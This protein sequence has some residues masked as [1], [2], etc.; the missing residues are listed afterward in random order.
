M[1]VKKDFEIVV[2]FPV[3]TGS[4]FAVGDI[5][6]LGEIFLPGW[7]DNRSIT[8]IDAQIIDPN[9]ATMQPVVVFH[10]QEPNIIGTSGDPY[11]YDNAGS[12]QSNIGFIPFITANQVSLS[13]IMFHNARNVGL[14]LPVKSQRLYVSA[15]VATGT[16]TL[17]F[18]YVTLKIKAVD[19]GTLNQVSIDLT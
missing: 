17:S 12:S 5:L 9:N 15:Y 6:F 4:A 3:A 19:N 2:K 14:F 16:P 1:E 13:T 8:V 10:D 7:R 18:D 11:Q